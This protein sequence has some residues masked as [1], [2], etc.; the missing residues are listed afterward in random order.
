MALEQVGTLGAG[1]LAGDLAPPRERGRVWGA[2][3]GAPLVP[4]IALALFAIMAIFGPWIAPYSPEANDLNARLAAPAWAG[5][6]GNHLLGTDKLGRDVLSRIIVGARSSFVVALVTIAVGGGL[7]T[8]IGLAAG[9]L[10]GRFEAVT[11]RL[12]D[13]TISF[14][15]ILLALLLAAV[16]GPGM[17]T[18]VLAVSLVLWAR[19]ARVIRGEVLSVKTRDFVALAQVAGLPWWRILIV[20]IL[21]NVMNTLVV[22]LTLDLG[23][24]IGVEATLSFLGA[25]I[26]PP[27]PTWGQMVADGRG[28]ITAAWWLALFPGLAIALVVLSFNLL[29][30]W[31][32]DFL[33]PKMRES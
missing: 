18:V 14:P 16:V 27:T 24:V 2:F 5:G 25:G 29:G 1:G 12:A 30:D 9:Y 7:G 13:S 15:L 20:H 19:I 21:P 32:R 28:Y 6:S 22:I 10:G 31:L 3:H 17:F 4:A 23:L 26:P 11:M 33:D 8:F